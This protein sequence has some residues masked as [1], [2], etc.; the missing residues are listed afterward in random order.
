VGG[1][2][3]EES[4]RRRTVGDRPMVESVQLAVDRSQD[5]PEERWPSGADGSQ[6]RHLDGRRMTG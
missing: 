6:R 5:V 4:G 1:R 2:L 3:A